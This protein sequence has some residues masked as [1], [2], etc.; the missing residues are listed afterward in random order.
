[1]TRH[2]NLLHMYHK[3]RA[4]ETSAKA[5]LNLVATKTAEA[6]KKWREGFLTDEELVDVVACAQSAREQLEIATSEVARIRSL[7]ED[8]V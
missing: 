3:A 6:L 1:M 4:T 8:T 7:L 2:A 5:N